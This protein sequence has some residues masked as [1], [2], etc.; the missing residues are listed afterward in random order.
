[1]FRRAENRKITTCASH[2]IIACSDLIAMIAQRAAWLLIAPLWV[3]SLALAQVQ[4]LYMTDS[5]VSVLESSDTA[6]PYVV[7][8]GREG[9]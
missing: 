1:M 2:T 4:V 7:G 5:A 8:F 3:C 6:Q 9:W